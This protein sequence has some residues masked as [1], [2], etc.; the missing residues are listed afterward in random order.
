MTCEK[1]SYQ[2][3]RKNMKPGD[4]VAFGGSS[5]FSK[6]IK[7]TTRS[8][9]SHV[10]IVMQTQMLDENSGR[11]FNQVM[12]STILDEFAGVTLSRF[13][14]RLR[15]YDG[16]VWWLPLRMMSG[17]TTSINVHFSISCSDKTTS[18]MTIRRHWHPLSTALMD[19]EVRDSQ[20]KN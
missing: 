6:L 19:W 5:A 14:E 17:V 10:G 3:A 20:R 8:H 16:E 1:I 2:D 4:V 12:E 13:S 11:F 7:F 9:V 18:P 15:D